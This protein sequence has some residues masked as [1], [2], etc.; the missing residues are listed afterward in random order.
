MLIA[1]KK[2]MLYSEAFR[3]TNIQLHEAFSQVRDEFEDHLTAVNENTNEIQANYELISNL[4]QKLNKLAE[5]LDSIEL[6]LQRQGMEIEEKPDFK[7]I[8]LTKRE[9][10]IFLILYT[11]EEVKGSVTYLDIAR[12]VCLP[13]DIVSSYISNMIRKG[14]PITK[15]YIANEA[16]LNLNPKFKAQQAKE[17]ILQIEQRRLSV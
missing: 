17:N 8:K 2:G 13:E 6:F 15:R 9:Q 5:R 12:K 16:H 1:E 10:E 14:I 11:S 4:D 7:P 3:E